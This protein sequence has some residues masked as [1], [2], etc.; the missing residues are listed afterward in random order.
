MPYMPLS[1][2]GPTIWSVS[3]EEELQLAYSMNLSRTHNHRQSQSNSVC[4]SRQVTVNEAFSYS[5]SILEQTQ[6][7]MDDSLGSRSVANQEF[8]EW[9]DGC[10]VIKAPRA[11]F[12][13]LQG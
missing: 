5:S 10:P 8:E 6:Q 7:E 1:P 4:Y 13:G 2:L 9:E 11:F 12:N 3:K